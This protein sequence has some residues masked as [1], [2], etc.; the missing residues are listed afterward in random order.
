VTDAAFYASAGESFEP[1]LPAASPWNT[2]TQSGVAM[3]GLLAQRLEQTPAT[4]E[5]MVARLTMDILRPAPMALTS[6]NCALTRDGRNMQNIEAVLEVDGRVVARA[7]VLRVR[8]A[9]SPPHQPRETAYPP[10]EDAPNKPLNRHYDR[11][12]ESRVL[13]GGLVERG[14]GAAW[15]R[16]RVDLVCGQ[17]ARPT[18]AAVMAADFG[19][20]LSSIHDSRQWSF[21]NVDLSIHF[22]RQPASDWIRVESRTLSEGDGSALV[23]TI[24]ADLEGVFGHAHQTLFITPQRPLAPRPKE[25]AA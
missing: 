22:I 3:A 16:P 21:A 12:M 14:P 10:P 11:G 4:A 7:S 18:A 25:S 6:V 24:L 17:A 9:T 2:A 20:A 8:V 5:M 23:E 15:V 1:L 19:G 13:F